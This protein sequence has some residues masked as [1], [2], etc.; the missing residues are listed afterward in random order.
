MFDIPSISMPMQGGCIPM[1]PVNTWLASWK[2]SCVDSNG[3]CYE[4]CTSES[5]QI[6]YTSECGSGLEMRW[7]WPGNEVGVAWDEVGTALVHWF[8][9]LTCIT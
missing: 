8:V 5:D 3:I 6:S 1:L 9:C 2:Y 4:L 7:E